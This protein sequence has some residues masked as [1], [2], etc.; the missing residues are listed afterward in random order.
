MDVDS[1]GMLNEQ[2]LK[3]FAQFTGFDGPAEAW[4]QEF[5]NLCREVNANV[6]EGVIIDHFVQLVNDKSD[7]GI[8]CSDQE[9]RGMLKKISQ[10]KAAQTRP[11][12]IK[13]AFRV[14]DVNGDGFLNKE[15][16]R[17]FAELG[18]FK[19]TPAEWQKEFRMLCSGVG[20]DAAAGLD[21]EEFRKVI[22]EGLGGTYTNEELKKMCN[23]L[24][25][26]GHGGLQPAVEAALVEPTLPSVKDVGPAAKTAVRVVPEVRQAL[27]AKVFQICDLD[28]NDLLDQKE[29]RPIVEKVGFRGTD[30]EWAVEYKK[31]CSDNNVDAAKGMKQDVLARLVEDNTDD[32]LFL[33]N[34]QLK[35]LCADDKGDL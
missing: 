24:D 21:P 6:A 1:D 7:S 15:E 16:M 32:G 5:A 14:L 8:Y 25:P 17:G 10:A 2:E 28:K 19:G 33:T 31:L 3:R 11:D 29:L 18:G 12:L 27:V 34:E 35:Q 23:K 9:F 13:R 4:S 20:A 26:E 30:D 22:D